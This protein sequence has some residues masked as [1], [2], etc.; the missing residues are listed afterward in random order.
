MLI[1]CRNRPLLTVIVRPLLLSIAC[2]VVKIVDFSSISS[3]ERDQRF[4]G[5]G[6]VLKHETNNTDC[7]MI[8]DTVMDWQIFD[9]S[10]LSFVVAAVRSPWSMWFFL[11][12]VVSR[13]YWVLSSEQLNFCLTCRRGIVWGGRLIHTI[14]RLEKSIPTQNQT[15][16][17]LV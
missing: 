17:D 13:I 10:S 7:L 8:S 14:F 12:P 9:C 6:L 2:F 16:Y 4:L 5:K 3:V 15:N 1:A 11:S